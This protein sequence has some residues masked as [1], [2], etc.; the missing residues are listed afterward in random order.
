MPHHRGMTYNK[1]LVT[2]LC[3]PFYK[4]VCV[5]L[6]ELRADSDDSVTCRESERIV[7]KKAYTHSHTPFIQST[8]ETA[9]LS[10]ML[11]RRQNPAK[12]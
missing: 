10:G 2:N 12:H 6:I 1:C 7:R 11:Y 5:W 8:F 3:M 4:C 9:C